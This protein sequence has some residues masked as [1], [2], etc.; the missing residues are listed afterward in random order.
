MILNN[1]CTKSEIYVLFLGSFIKIIMELIEVN[2]KARTNIVFITKMLIVLIIPLN[3]FISLSDSYWASVLLNFNGNPFVTLNPVLTILSGL[4]IILP[5]VL[6]EH[7]LNS[8]PISQSLKKRAIFACLL[9]WSI[10]MILP[11][12]W[13][14]I[15]RSYYYYSSI[16]RT[17]PL[18]TLAFF[19]ALPLISRE[20]ALR[21]V[22]SDH[23]T[24]SYGHIKSTIFKKIKRERILSGLLWASLIF[25]PFVVSVIV[26]YWIPYFQ[27]MSLFYQFEFS[28]LLIS[29]RFIIDYIIFQFIALEGIAIP[30]FSL[31][32][33]LRFVFVRDIFRFKDG[34][35]RRGRFLSVGI[36]GEILPSI[37]L[38]SLMLVT[39]RGLI[40]IPLFI[41]IPL[42]S[43]FGLVFIRFSKIV[44]VQE[45]IWPEHQYQMWFEKEQEPYSPEPA[46]ENIKVPIGYLLVSQVRKR[47]KQ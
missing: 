30:F 16:I 22:T 20:I 34:I 43:I 24:L 46:E 13:G 2:P 42:L 45:E 29:E 32:S 17:I 18:L 21:S 1:Q 31:L 8:K 6:F 19:V 40:L 5:G 7:Q 23:H 38:T 35:L 26:S 39:A 47:M 3:G 28:G 14:I 33:G 44:P 9:S 37:I 10:S 25:S 27:F 4:L 11:N 36:L 15:P 12:S 41:P